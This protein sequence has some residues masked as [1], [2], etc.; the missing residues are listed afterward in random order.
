MDSLN[1]QQR[2]ASTFRG[3]HLLVLA[4]AGTG[5][6]RTIIARAKWLI[7]SGVQPQRILILS[8]TRKSAREIVE[9]IAN[10]IPNQESQ[11]LTGHTFHSWCMGI[12]KKYPKF[13]PQSS[14][15]L[16]DRDDQKSCFKLLCGKKW[17]LH[18]SDGK[19]IS[20]III[21][22]VYSYAVNAR[23]SLS[24]AFRMVVYNNASADKDVEEE[25]IEIQEI[26]KSYLEYKNRHQY[27]DYDDILLIVS[28]YLKQNDQLRQFIANQYD[29]IL[30]DEM[31]DT[32]PLQYELLHSFYDSC[33]L[34]CVGDDAQSIYGFRGA[35]FETIHKFC[36][37]V[38]NAEVAKL[39][40]NYRSTPEIL[41]L[42]NWLIEE[43]P[44]NYDKILSSVKDNNTKPQIIYGDSEYDV[45]YDVIAK[46]IDH[47]KTYGLKWCDNLVLARSQ[48]ALRCVEGR[49]LR[50]KIPYML[51]AGSQLMQSAHIRDVVSAMR[52]VCNFSDEIAWSRY[53]QIW[54][55]IGPAKAAKIIGQVLSENKLD[56]CLM[57][58]IDLGLQPEIAETL[59]GISDLHNNPRKSILRALS[60]MEPQLKKLYDNNWE[61]RKKDFKIL[62]ELAS[63][64]PTITDFLQEYV[65]NPQLEITNKEGETKDS[66]VLSTIHSAKGLEADS[67]YIVDASPSN[68]PNPNAISRGEKEIEEERRCLYVAMTRA[69]NNLYIYS[70]QHSAHAIDTSKYFLQELPESL[71]EIEHISSSTSD[72]YIDGVDIKPID[73]MAGFDFAKTLSEVKVTEHGVCVENSYVNINSLTTSER[74]IW[75]LKDIVLKCIG[76]MPT[77]IDRIR[78]AEIIRYDNH[79]TLIE[80]ICRLE[81][82]EIV[83]SRCSLYRKEKFLSVLLHE[84]AHAR[85][86]SNDLT[87][88]FENELSDMLG[89]L[90]ASLCEQVGYDKT[91]VI[92]AKT[93]NN[94]AFSYAKCVCIKC[95]GDSFD[96]NEDKTYA[97]CDKCGKE[98]IGGYSELVNLNRKMI[99][100]YGFEFIFRPKLD[101]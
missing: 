77:N 45:A 16:L 48:F 44:L 14:F 22:D 36:D 99:E 87:K 67:V 41:V 85:S 82:R 50:A 33:H 3:K 62:A 21:L 52:I 38:P 29:H 86:E 47:F 46:M 19:K 39:T 95:G 58:L 10:E 71:V 20:P 63:D 40:I 75:E 49:C 76:G 84:L 11:G 26:I 32:N 68:Y 74:I 30:I 7:N 25:R 93:L 100:K 13:F 96:C 9:R 1:E 51:Y 80:G 23:C 90:A 83:I 28:E 18:D 2:Y 70:N 56:A 6:T 73:Y 88:D 42:S 43:S 17:N 92:P 54:D 34:F 97:K 57:I 89:L 24:D 64:F 78:I 65:L 55:G 4:G 37:I 79:D 69:K 72:V 35:D 61:W 81:N 12:I 53:L 27:I 91:K 15:V 94:S 5:K 59:V 60:A 98:Y 66:V 8:F 31:Q 101:T